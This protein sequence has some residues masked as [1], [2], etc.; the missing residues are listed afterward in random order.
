MSWA[1]FS[2]GGLGNGGPGASTGFSYRGRGT[3]RVTSQFSAGYSRGG[4]GLTGYGG[5]GRGS[6]IGRPGIGSGGLL[7]EVSSGVDRGSET[8]RVAV[9][10]TGPTVFQ[11]WWAVHAGG[12][13]IS[14]VVGT[15]DAKATHSRNALRGT[16]V[17]AAARDAERKA[18]AERACAVALRCVQFYRLPQSNESAAA[19]ADKPLVDVRVCAPGSVADPVAGGGARDESKKTGATSAVVTS[20]ILTSASAASVPAQEKKDCVMATAWS[21][22]FSLL[23]SG[24]SCEPDRNGSSSS[25][26]AP[27]LS[28]AAVTGAGSWSARSGA[29]SLSSTPMATDSSA[30][31]LVDDVE[32]IYLVDY[33]ADC[34]EAGVRAALLWLLERDKQIVVECAL[35]AETLAACAAA[36]AAVTRG[37]PEM[38]RLFLYRGGGCRRGWSAAAVT[39]LR[40]SLGVRRATGK[41]DCKPSSASSPAKTA[42]GGRSAFTT[43]STKTAAPPV[44][45]NGGFSVFDFMD[46]HIGGALKDAEGSSGGGMENERSCAAEKSSVTVTPTSTAMATLNPPEATPKAETKHKSSAPAPASIAV[47]AAASVVGAVRHICMVVIGHGSPLPIDSAAVASLGIMDSLG[48]DAVAVVL[49]LLDWTCPDMVVGRVHRRA[50]DTLQPLCVQAEMYYGIEETT[51]ESGEEKESVAGRAVSASPSYLCVSLHIATCGSGIRHPTD[52][53]NGDR[54]VF[55][56]SLRIVGTKA[57]LTVDHPLL[58]GASPSTAAPTPSAAMTTAAGPAADGSSLLTGTATLVASPS[59]ASSTAT[60]VSASGNATMPTA[61]KVSHSYRLATQGVS[62]ASGQCERREEEVTVG[63]AEPCAEF[64]T[65]QHVRS[66]LNVTATSASPRS[67]AGLGSYQLYNSRYANRGVGVGFGA[68]NGYYDRGRGTR[69]RR[70]DFGG[71]LGADRA[72]ASGTSVTA[73]MVDAESAALD[74]QHAWLVQV[75]VESILASA[76]KPSL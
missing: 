8:P 59:G 70:T 7:H 18:S 61:P 12:L 42:L 25:V 14:V 54:G 67:G 75:V 52:E 50:P 71:G 63:S 16:A 13:R 3:G 10:G 5:Y 56:Q 51:K 9:I 4:G 23:P 38:K 65:W 11:Q 57:V 37:K 26:R 72:A 74:V 55:Q 29:A 60:A 6:G 32:V 41:T 58:P 35:S 66:Q 45:S 34:D 64:R 27:F 22:F 20:S 19:G 62:P 15:D 30:E 28:S 69:G 47:D 39:Q 48:W 33:G 31:S 36:A 40:K 44:D 21:W 24:Q 49:H 17:A 68:R 76:A 53:D 1:G 46:S 2:A 43:V 73:E